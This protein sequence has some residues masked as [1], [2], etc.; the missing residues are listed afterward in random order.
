[1]GVFD[2]LFNSP[3]VAGILAAVGGI[4]YGFFQKGK[5]NR[6]KERADRA[7]AEADAAKEQTH[8]VRKNAKDIVDAVAAGRGGLPDPAKDPHNRDNR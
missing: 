6:A 5:A 8:A 7:I 3:I 1:M 2:L 4:L